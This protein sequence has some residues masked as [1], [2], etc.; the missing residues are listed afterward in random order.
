MS[1]NNIYLR[2]EYGDALL[3]EPNDRIS[4]DEM[5][6]IALVDGQTSME[7]ITRKVPPSVRG[8]LDAI[9]AR[10][11]S[12]KIIKDTGERL[13]AIS[14]E[15]V[16]QAEVGVGQNSDKGSSKELDKILAKLDANKVR[17]QEIEVGFQ[18]LK[19]RISAY[20]DITLARFTKMQ[21]DIRGNNDD[22]KTNLASDLEEAQADLQAVEKAMVEQQSAIDRTLRLRV[23]PQSLDHLEK[24]KLEKDAKVASSHPH[25]KKL[26]GLEF[27]RGFAN[28]E[29]LRFLEIAQ[30]QIVDRGEAVLKEGDVGMPFFI[31]LSGSVSVY[32][33][34]HKMATLDRGDFF[35]EFAYLSGEEPFRTARVEADSTCEFLKINPLDIEFSPVQLRLNVVE[36]LLRGQVRRTLVSSK[37]MSRFTENDTSD[38][39]D[40]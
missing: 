5:L 35:G 37:P 12:E 36:A 1:M 29:L 26:R 24:E 19:M 20:V 2:T 34:D 7:G 38:S 10:L 32:K 3:E 25:Y 39:Q 33:G 28:V 14:S 6:L 11:L 22:L 17:Q 30:W 13:E 40:S 23:S 18:Q 31:I 8:K 9:F 15:D 21:K 4:G 16:P 27:F